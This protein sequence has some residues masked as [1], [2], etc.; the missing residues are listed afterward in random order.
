MSAA[1]F[2]PE[3]MGPVFDAR[4]NGAGELLKCDKC[5]SV[6]VPLHEYVDLRVCSS[7]LAKLSADERTT[8]A[9][10][11]LGPTL[12]SDEDLEPPP[13]MLERTDGMRLLYP[14]KT[15]IVFGEPEAGKG[16]FVAKAAKE[17][18]DAG[19]HVLY[20]DFDDQDRRLIVA[21][22]RALGVTDNQIRTQFHYITPDEPLDEEGRKAIDLVLHS[23]EPTLAILD[24]FTDAL[25]LHNVRLNENT[26]IAK[27]MRDLP[28]ALR[29]CGIA[30]VLID[31]VPKDGSSHG[32]SI[33]G[34]H[35]RAKCDVSYELVLRKSLGRGMTGRSVVKEWKDRPG[36]VK[37]LG[38]N[39]VVA[40][41][42]GES[43]PGDAMDLALV[44][45]TE[46]SGKKRLTG[47]MEKVSKAV[48]AKPGLSITQLREAVPG[49]S[50]YI[51]SARE[52]LIEE[53][54]VE[55][56]Q[57]GQAT[58]HYSI[59]PYREAEDPDA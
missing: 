16:W 34:M 12:D 57:E 56:R 25:T 26:E 30:V 21:R 4:S 50:D 15:H 31:H 8:W 44:P 6:G 11:D 46:K 54:Y 49:G 5:S 40:E 29:R 48:E 39:R 55:P 43:L 52:T 18:L 19:E 59:R 35:K 33:G 37:R 53:G 36:H 58:R 38:K 51:D 24:G 23:W 32:Y 3:V 20:I 2:D 41:L 17:Q 28:S 9:P 42:V 22:L 1:D 27:W 47:Y 13:A 10:V 45:P 14:A 7:C